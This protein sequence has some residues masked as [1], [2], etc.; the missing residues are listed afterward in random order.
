MLCFE[1]FTFYVNLNDN[2]RL[3][4]PDDASRNYHTDDEFEYINDYIASYTAENKDFPMLY[5]SYEGNFVLK[6]RI[7]SEKGL[8]YLF[9][10][11]EIYFMK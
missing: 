9:K 2:Y 4:I 8:T 1:N 7:L 6:D 3:K 10:L 5:Y 11:R